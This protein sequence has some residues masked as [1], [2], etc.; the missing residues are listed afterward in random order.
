M[1]RNA[2]QLT[3]EARNQFAPT[4]TLRASINYGNPILAQRTPAGELTGVSVVLAT[5]LA[6]RLEV[7]LELVPFDAAGKAFG[8]LSAGKCD[9]GFLAIDPVR[10]TAI[11]YTASYV[12]I[13]GAF[14]VRNDSGF[15]DIVD[16]DVPGVR[17]AAGLNTAYDLY[18]RRELK[19]AQLVYA[20]LSSE[21]IELFLDGQA[22]VAAGILQP[23][24]V[25]SRQHDGL[26]LAGDRFMS[27]EQAMAM[28]KGRDLAMTYL[29]QFVEDAKVSGLVRQALDASGQTEAKIAPPRP[30]H[31]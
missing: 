20:P 9:I 8:A 11:D 5:E 23:L 31:G 24:E 14:L 27:I 2:E 4:G 10:G 16:I 25:A 21:A 22:D 28:P 30:D 6:R 17:I 3:A 18:L 7:P 29:R 1:I 26:R 12:L 15:F 13:E 19:H